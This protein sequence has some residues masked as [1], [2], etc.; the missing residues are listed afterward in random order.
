LPAS[1]GAG[2]PARQSIAIVMLAASFSL[3]I[4]SS[5]PEK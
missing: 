1:A 4:M 5:F 3:V 2:L